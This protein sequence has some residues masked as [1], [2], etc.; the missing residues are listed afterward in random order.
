MPSH[1]MSCNTNPPVIELRERRKNRLGQLLGDV[2]VHV[3][4]GVVGCFGCV[5]VEARSGA[6]IV[7]VVFT[8]DIQATFTPQQNH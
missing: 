3:I 5:D 4:A 6:E 2:G 7:G 1:T 8:L